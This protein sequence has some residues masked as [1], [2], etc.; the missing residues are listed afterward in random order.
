MI[1]EHLKEYDV[2]EDEKF[3]YCKSCV[4]EHGYK[5]LIYPNLNAEMIQ[6]YDQQKTIYKKVPEHNPECHVYFKKQPI[7]ITSPQEHKIYYTD[8]SIAYIKLEC[9]VSPSVKS[10]FWYV[11]DKFIG[12][13]KKDEEVFIK[14]TPQKAKISC[15]DD[16]GNTKHIYI[17]IKNM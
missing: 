4:P 2:S 1:C 8:E 13:Y 11:N 5:R 7:Q 14:L 15:A 9:A 6:Y 3:S 12:K 10:V 17:D 16:L